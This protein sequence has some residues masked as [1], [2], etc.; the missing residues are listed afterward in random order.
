MLLS[1]ADIAVTAEIE[2]EFE[3][4]SAAEA[5]RNMSG[6]DDQ[7]TTFQNVDVRQDVEIAVAVAVGVQT[8]TAHAYVR[9]GATLD[10]VGATSVGSTV[11][12]LFLAD[13]T[14]GEPMNPR[15]DGAEGGRPR[16][17]RRAPG[18]HAGPGEQPLQRVGRSSLAGDPKNA[19]GD[20]FV[21]GASVAL[22]FFT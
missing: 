2:Q 7:S 9:S 6:A 4:A 12:Y 17:L 13:I 18:R 10:A 16:R 15:R 20:I 11:A 19:S 5:T 14:E 21:L 3:M 22:S 8:N 1:G